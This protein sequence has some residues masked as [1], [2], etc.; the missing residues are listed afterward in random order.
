MADGKTA[1]RTGS[2]AMY[3]GRTISVLFFSTA[4]TT[5]AATLA[6]VSGGKMRGN[7]VVEF[8]NMDVEM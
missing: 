5:E 7:L 4:S 2:A 8:S 3:L 6:A 1:F